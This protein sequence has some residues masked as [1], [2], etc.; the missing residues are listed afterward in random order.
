MIVISEDEQSCI[1]H[2]GAKIPTMKRGLHS[3]KATQAANAISHLATLQTPLLRHTPFFTCAIT[4][5]AIVQLSAYS[6]KPS[7]FGKDSIRQRVNLAIGL[8]KNISEIW[9]VAAILAQRVK[10]IAK[11]LLA[12]KP[13]SETHS[14]DV[15]DPFDLSMSIGGSLWPNELGKFAV[16]EP[17]DDSFE[18]DIN[19]D[20]S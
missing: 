1:R 8:L 9:D 6:T 12:S 4:L 5:S 7:K 10:K 20:F 3:A 14:L 15:E 2:T 11:V 17:A 13:W 18:F 19:P 16:S